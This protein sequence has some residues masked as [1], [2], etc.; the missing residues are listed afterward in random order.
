MDRGVNGVSLP[1]KK[2]GGGLLT[3]EPSALREGS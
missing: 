3:E 2:Q 1:P